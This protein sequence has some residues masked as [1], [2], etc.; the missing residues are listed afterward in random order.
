MEKGNILVIGNSGVGKSTLINAVLG[1]ETAR[2]S[3]GTSGT[4]TE[5]AIY[6]N[7]QVPFRLIDTIGFEPSFLKR[8]MAI[9]SVKRWGK[10]CAKKGRKNTVINI[11]W[12]CVEGTSSKLFAE[13]I[14]NISRA[15]AMWPSIPILV[16]ITKSYSV[17]DREK[18]IEMVRNAF[19]KQKK[20]SKNLRGVIPVVAET[21]RLNDE[22]FAPPDGISELIEKTNDLLPEGIKAGKRD[23]SAFKLKRKRALSQTVVGAA[24][25]SAVIVGAVPI[26]IPDAAV[27]VPVEVAE[28]N[29]IAKVYGI[30]KTEDSNQF[31][32]SIIQAGTV[33][34]AAKQ[35]IN[36]IK[37]IPG[38]N[39]ATAVLNSII[40]A[41]IVAT[42]GEV[43]A[44]IFE[45]IYLGHKTI[46]DIDWVKQIVE[47]K[48]ANQFINNVG[49]VL[50]QIGNNTDKENIV[51]TILRIFSSGK[52]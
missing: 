26:P 38:I 52:S 47:S 9:N 50:K 3:Y 1:E 40:A 34:L 42:L 29:A 45:Q 46:N 11:I 51:K 22:A 6:E 16:V 49:E 14:R 13:T 7:D 36:A 23:L 24:T 21:Y 27:L 28:V 8:E 17:P 2:T 39:L 35:A 30:K 25:T 5:L 32:N 33:S 44:Y 18:N 4:T 12:F 37:L 43:S 15:T 20:C 19:A 41:S 31:F 48:F 10:D